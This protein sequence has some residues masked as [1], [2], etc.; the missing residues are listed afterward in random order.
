MATR[1]GLIVC[2]IA[3]VSLLKGATAATYTVGDELG[4]TIPPLGSVAYKTWARGKV[5][6]IGDVIGKHIL[7]NI[8]IASFSRL[9]VHLEYWFTSSLTNEEL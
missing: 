1:L 2:L 5:F 4:W 8:E 9:P 3:V 7:N 6:E